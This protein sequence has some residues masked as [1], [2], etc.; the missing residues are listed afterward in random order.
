LRR[1]LNALERKYYSQLK[2]VF[3]AI[4]QLMA[5]QCLE[6]SDRGPLQRAPTPH[7]RLLPRARVPQSTAPR[8]SPSGGT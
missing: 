2:V 3:D 6:P 5:P 4:R 8:V 1:Q 7:L